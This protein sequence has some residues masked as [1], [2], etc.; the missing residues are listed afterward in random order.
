MRDLNS[1]R[2]KD[3]EKLISLVCFFF[4]LLIS[5][6]MLSQLHVLFLLKIFFLFKKFQPISFF[7]A[8]PGLEGPL[9]YGDMFIDICEQLNDHEFIKEVD[10]C[11][12]KLNDE[13]SLSLM[14]QSLENNK[15][16][17]Y[18]DFSMNLFFFFF[19]NLLLF[20][21]FFS[22]GFLISS[23]FKH[24]VTNYSNFRFYRKFAVF[25]FFCFLVESQFF[26][27]LKQQGVCATFFDKL[28]PFLFNFAKWK[29]FN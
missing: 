2:K 19:T 20:I 12:Q 1:K 22:A 14:I 5:T 10:F 17:C 15:S 18:L 4:F 6:Y 9:E 29:Y 28:F 25:L 23:L 21:F 11:G 8:E 24:F 16:I 7:F 27:L 26:F 13:A 3:A